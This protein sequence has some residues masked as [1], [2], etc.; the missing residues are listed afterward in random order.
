MN[1][2]ATI[3]S[4]VNPEPK[5]IP[6]LRRLPQPRSTPSEF[7][8]TYEDEYDTLAEEAEEFDDHRPPSPF[9]PDGPDAD[10]SI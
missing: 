8:Y 3:S 9:E 4:N 10:P 2:L 5:P 1:F 6:P 7:K